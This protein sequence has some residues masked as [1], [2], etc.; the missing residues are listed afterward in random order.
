M[1]NN[2]ASAI[3]HPATNVLAKCSPQ[4]LDGIL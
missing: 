2:T 4:I 1:T 3:P